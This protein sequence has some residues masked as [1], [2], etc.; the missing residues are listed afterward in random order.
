MLSQEPPKDK[1][2]KPHMPNYLKLK[3]LEK[4]PQP[5]SPKNSHNAMLTH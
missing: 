4:L 3:L 5:A 1:K 2:Q